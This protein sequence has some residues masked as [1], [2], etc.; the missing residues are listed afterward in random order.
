M[1]W[2]SLIAGA[3][4]SI[5]AVGGFVL[6]WRRFTADRRRGV[7]TDERELRRDTIADRDALIDQMQEEMRELRARMSH[8][9]IE[10][11]LDQQWARA[12]VDHIYRGSPPPPPARP[13]RP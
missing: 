3:S 1:D 2:T 4:T 6:T 12:L 10:Q 11:A 9:E 13:T 5:V 7:A 8:I